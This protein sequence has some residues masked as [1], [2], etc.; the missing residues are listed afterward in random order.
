MARG[1]KMPMP[2]AVFKQQ[3]ADRGYT[4]A[5]D[6]TQYSDPQ[7]IYAM[8]TN[9]GIKCEIKPDMYTLGLQ[10]KYL[11][12]IRIA[13]EAEGYEF[14]KKT[15][16]YYCIK[17]EDDDDWFEVFFDIVDIIENIE[18]IPQNRRTSA[19]KVFTKEVA[20]RNIFEKIARR[21]RNAY[22]NKDQYMLDAARQL[23]SGDDI[24]HLLT[25]GESVAR[26]DTN[27][28]REHIVPCILIHNHAVEMTVNGATIATV[29]QMIKTNLAIVLITN[30]EA[31]RLD[32]ELGLQTVM[33]EGW[34]WG[35][36]PFARLVA[37][38]IALK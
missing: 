25:V 20:E 30:E 3:C 18:T 14:T 7:F 6:Q 9:N 27:T 11:E 8:R 35:Q 10:S 34:Q 16:K 29:A 17:H 26:T 19:V 12:D 37:A 31:D 24:D 13:C 2:F 21:Y 22:D 28:Y 1:Q 36:D 15:G 4:N 38:N 5:I 23:L 32:T 33:P